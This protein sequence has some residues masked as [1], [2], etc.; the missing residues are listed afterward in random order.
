MHLSHSALRV[1]LARRAFSPIAIVVSLVLVIACHDND[2]IPLIGFAGS[3]G[4]DSA[5]AGRSGA[6]GASTAGKAGSAAGSHSAGSAGSNQIGDVGGAAG[7][8]GSTESGSGG[9]GGSGG[10]SGSAGS[11]GS[12][13]SGGLAGSSGSG[14]ASSSAGSGGSGPSSNCAVG[15]ALFA[16][17]TYADANGNQFILKIAQKATTFAL[18]PAGVANS[19][20]PPQLF[21]VDRVCAPSGALIANDASS[22]YRVDFI[23]TGSQLAVCLSPPAPSLDAALVVPP[24]DTAHVTDTGCS[25][26]AFKI[27]SKGAL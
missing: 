9:R 19:T 22:S 18:V 5:T 10:T 17:G 2:T 21:R 8:G 16:E 3:G 14:G 24:A 25:G 23:Q 7:F 26:Q 11:A 13:G 15:G 20:Q 1:A 12:A 4:T 27:Y 6:S